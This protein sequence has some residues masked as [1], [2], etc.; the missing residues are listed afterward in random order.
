MTLTVVF[1]A[2]L[3]FL[4]TFRIVMSVHLPRGT[5]GKVMSLVSG[6]VALVL[7]FIAI[8]DLPSVSPWFI[9]TFI[10]VSLIFAGVARIPLALGLRKAEHALAPAHGG[11]HA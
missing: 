10:G 8:S 9:G 11:A 4:G 2:Y 6:L 3:V 1:L 5:P 7:A